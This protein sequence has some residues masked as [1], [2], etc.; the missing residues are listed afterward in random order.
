MGQS[1]NY[2]SPRL[3]QTQLDLLCRKVRDAAD[4]MADEQILCLADSLHDALRER[5]RLRGKVHH[6]I[7]ERLCQQGGPA[8]PF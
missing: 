8:F 4:Y 1:L 2:Q 6:Q 5:R 3:S 7:E